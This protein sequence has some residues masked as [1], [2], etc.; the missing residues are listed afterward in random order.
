MEKGLLVSTGQSCRLGW[1]WLGRKAQPKGA[2]PIVR[3]SSQAPQA[4]GTSLPP[5]G[6]V[7]DAAELRAIQQAVQRQGR[8]RVEAVQAEARTLARPVGLNTVQLLKACSTGMGLAPA[9]AM[10]V[11]PLPC[12]LGS[13]SVILVTTGDS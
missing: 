12:S 8:G 13:P 10:K 3:I 9:Q 2:N 5:G 11:C 7:W 6:E 4:H 1:T